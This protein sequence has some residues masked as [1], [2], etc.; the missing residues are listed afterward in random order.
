M[1]Q[2][3]IKLGLCPKCYKFGDKC[4]CGY[5]YGFS[6]QEELE[7]YLD[8]LFSQK[9]FIGT[10]ISKNLLELNQR[11]KVGMLVYIQHT[12]ILIITQ[13][14]SL[15]YEDNELSLNY[16]Q[17]LYSR[18]ELKTIY[19]KGINEFSMEAQLRYAEWQDVLIEDLLDTSKSIRFRVNKVKCHGTLKKSEEKNTYICDKCNNSIILNVKKIP[20]VCPFKNELRA[21]LIL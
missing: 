9:E 15:T 7:N 17:L 5:N 2:A 11:P 10:V 12:G 4:S 18:G 16:A 8:H 6:S 1:K 20:T 19:V 21:R 3:E 14:D 13:K